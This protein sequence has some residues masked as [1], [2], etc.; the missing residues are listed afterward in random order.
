M[1]HEAEA[2]REVCRRYIGKKGRAAATFVHKGLE[3]V[4]PPIHKA[5]DRVGM[6][7][8]VEGQLVTGVHAVELKRAIGL[9]CKE[10]LE[11][12]ISA[13]EVEH[14]QGAVGIVL[15]MAK[16]LSR[17]LE[18][19][20]PP[21]PRRLSGARERWGVQA[22]KPVVELDEPLCE[23]ALHSKSPAAARM[24]VWKRFYCR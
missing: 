5:R 20:L 8:L 16:V 10:R 12:E 3:H 18:R 4:E 19:V 13:G 17:D 24:V 9:L 21:R 7:R 22:I 11:A 23:S 14:A 15:A 1:V 2:D 6:P